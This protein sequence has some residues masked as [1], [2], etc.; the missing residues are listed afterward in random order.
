MNVNFF[1]DN[2]LIE[3]ALQEIQKLCKKQQSE[4]MIDIISGNAG[5]ILA[6]L[7]LYKLINEE[8]LLKLSI[9]LGNDLVDNAINEPYGWSWNYKKS[10]VANA[11]HNLTGFSHGAAGIGYSLLELFNKTDNKKFLEADYQCF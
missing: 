4:H 9:I 1:S 6:L 11:Q 8:N 2:Y 3:L 10:G 7:D 5:G